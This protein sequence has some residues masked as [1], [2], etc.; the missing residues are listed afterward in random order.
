MAEVIIRSQE[1]SGLSFRAEI[2]VE[3]GLEIRDTAYCGERGR[4]GVRQV[5]AEREMKC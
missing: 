2:R 3:A 4:Q 1:A 5:N